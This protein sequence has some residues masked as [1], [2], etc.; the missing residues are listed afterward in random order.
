MFGNTRSSTPVV[1]SRVVLGQSGFD[2]KASGRILARAGGLPGEGRLYDRIGIGNFVDLEQ[3][4][5]TAAIN[6]SFKSDL[7]S[8][9]LD[10]DLPAKITLNGKLGSFWLDG[11]KIDPTAKASLS[12]RLLDLGA[13]DSR[14]TG[15]LRFKASARTSGKTD[16]GFEIDRKVSVHHNMPN[17]TVYGNVSYKTNNRE[18]GLWK[19]TSSFGIHQDIKFSGMRFAARLGMTPEGA[20][21][22]DLRL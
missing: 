3:N 14:Q 16:H 21:V 8:H 13:S 5:F 6:K 15:F 10:V 11:L 17:T 7:L 2:N 4:K 22:Y 12:V 1:G 19:S 9:L 18:K 20:F